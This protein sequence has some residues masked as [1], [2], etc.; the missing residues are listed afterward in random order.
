MS[1]LFGERWDRKAETK[2]R[3]EDMKIQT[4]KAIELETVNA[5]LLEALQEVSRYAEHDELC[6]R[7]FRNGTCD[8]DYYKARGA[9][10][11]AIA[12]ATTSPP[13]TD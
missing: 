12:R 4:A 7:E 11:K 9:T 13:E 2:E 10:Q 5:E 6:D 3:L 8:C 1:R